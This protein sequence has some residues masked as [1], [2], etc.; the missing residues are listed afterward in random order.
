MKF[1]SRLQYAEKHDESVCVALSVLINLEFVLIFQFFFSLVDNH[2]LDLG[3]QFSYCN[4]G[5][6]QAVRWQVATNK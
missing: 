5:C 6:Q 3:T 2:S 4:G 1:V